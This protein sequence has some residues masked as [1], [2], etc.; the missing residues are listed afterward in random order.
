MKNHLN[1][2]LF[3]ISIQFSFSQGKY[4]DGPYKDYHETGELMLE[5]QYKKGKRVGEWKGYH[6]NGQIANIS[7]FTDGKKEIP[8]ISYY[9]DGSIKRTIEKQGDIHIE[10]SYY[11]SGSLFYERVY[12]SGYYKEFREDSTLKIE[13]NYRDFELYGKWKLYDDSENLEWSINYE[14][15]YRNGMYQNYY[16]NGQLKVQGVI[17]NDK[18]NGE[19]KRFDESGN[20]IWKGFY[21]NDAFTKSWIRY[22]E[23]GKKIEKIKIR[24][25]NS[26]LDIKV[27]D[28][29]DGVIEKVPVYRGCEIVFGNKARKKCMSQR[30]SEHIAL[31]FNKD[32]LSSL[33]LSPGRKRIF[34]SFKIDKLGQIRY[35][36]ARGPHPK[37]EREAIR[38]IKEMPYLKPGTQRG[39]P[40][41]V[42]FSLPIVFEIK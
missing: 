40:V 16:A 35:I 1:I 8:E 15:G 23:K 21:K 30:V 31:H 28:V 2:F 4:K 29:P 14:N 38:V 12:K 10:K 27:T 36:K 42:P 32:L 17:L 24:D 11:E 5:G 6:K 26:I 41:T 22:D 13:A 39:Q 20:L 3:L 33:G 9:E 37:A 18:K 19:E 7:N 25:D 34:V